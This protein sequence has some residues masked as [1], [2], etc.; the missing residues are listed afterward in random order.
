MTDR[1]LHRLLERAVLA[2]EKLAGIEPPAAKTPK[3]ALTETQ[4]KDLVTVIRRGE[5]V[6]EWSGGIP[7]G[8]GDVTPAAFWAHKDD[9]A[10]RMKRPTRRS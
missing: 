6:P 8:G 2:L 7:P 9:Q 3:P 1:Q 5:T 10:A 4:R